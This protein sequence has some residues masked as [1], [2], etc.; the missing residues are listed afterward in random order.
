[1]Y[2]NAA[3]RLLN[4]GNESLPQNI[5]HTLTP[6]NTSMF[7]LL[8]FFTSACCFSPTN[9]FFI[10]WSRSIFFFSSSATA[11][12]CALLQDSIKAWWLS[13]LIAPPMLFSLSLTEKAKKL[14]CVYFWVDRVQI[15]LKGTPFS[16]LLD[17]DLSRFE[18]TRLKPENKCSF[19]FTAP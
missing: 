9:A 7:H 13:N 18:L 14:S 15:L 8:F 3:R 19:L 5:I 17:M 11:L 6:F 16:T 10:S 1:M 4:E 12:T 2:F